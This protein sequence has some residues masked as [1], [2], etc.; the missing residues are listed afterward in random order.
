MLEGR[1]GELEVIREILGNGAVEDGLEEGLDVTQPDIQELDEMNMPD[2]AFYKSLNQA[3]RED[4]DP[5]CQAS[6]LD[7]IWEEREEMDEN[8][9]RKAECKD[10]EGEIYSALDYK[11]YRGNSPCVSEQDIAQLSKIDQIDQVTIEKL[12]ELDRLSNKLH[13]DSVS[14]K[15]LQRKLLE[16]PM[17]VNEDKKE[18]PT[19]DNWTFTRTLETR[20]TC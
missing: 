5:S 19:E 16:S 14:I 1:L 7:M 20:R 4:L 8:S 15:Q 2:E 6:Q 17:S 11:D 18:E 13:Q 3:Y 12:N 10:A 9:E